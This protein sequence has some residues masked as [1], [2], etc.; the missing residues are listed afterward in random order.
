MALVGRTH[1]LHCP[2]SVRQ[3]PD[4]KIPGEG[5]IL[6]QQHEYKV[7]PAPRKA[8]KA[9]NL[10]TGEDRFAHALTRVM[11]EMAEGGWEYLRTDTLPME[12]RTGLTGRTTTEYQHMMV[13]VRRLTTTASAQAA[14]VLSGDAQ[15]AI[16]PA[17]PV[18]L[19]SPLPASQ[20][21]AQRT[22]QQDGAGAP[23]LGPATSRD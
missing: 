16:I 10:K 6:M 17:A 22:T 4:T 1:Y 18:V 20:L 21:S 8:D 3:W 5:K 12:E 13:F 7:V 14:A 2:A 19:G 15:S 23:S 11:N 9:R